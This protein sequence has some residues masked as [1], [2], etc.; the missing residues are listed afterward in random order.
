MISA[1]P[2]HSA[3]E[4]SPQSSPVLVGG[5]FASRV[6]RGRSGLESSPQSSPQ[7][8]P[9]L[10]E[11]I[12]V[13]PADLVLVVTVSGQRGGRRARRV[14]SSVSGRQGSCPKSQDGVAHADRVGGSAQPRRPAARPRR[15]RQ[16]GIQTLRTAGSR[17]PPNVRADPYQSATPARFR[18]VWLLPTTSGPVPGSGRDRAVGPCPPCTSGD[19]LLPTSEV[20]TPR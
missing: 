11:A 7:S 1:T 10:V 19:G 17:A 20:Q 9:L 15:P 14:R 8:S 12:E 18:T 6:R 4:S 13:G 3:L 2:P 16:D 5:R